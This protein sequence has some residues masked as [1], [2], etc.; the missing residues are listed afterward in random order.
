MSTYASNARSD[1]RC[2][3]VL[4]LFSGVVGQILMGVHGGLIVHRMLTG[5]P[6]VT[7][8]PHRSHGQRPVTLIS[9]LHLLKVFFVS[10]VPHR[11]S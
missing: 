4:H 2:V 6:H 11:T 1:F 9:E 7:Q 5:L 10:T 8:S 3:T